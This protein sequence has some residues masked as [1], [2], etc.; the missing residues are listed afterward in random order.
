MSRG[1]SNPAIPRRFVQEL[2]HH[3]EEVLCLPQ[4]EEKN[5]SKSVPIITW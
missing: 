3:A 5:R 4:W 1:E 2:R